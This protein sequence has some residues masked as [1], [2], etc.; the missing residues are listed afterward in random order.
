MT[1]KSSKLML[2]IN[3]MEVLGTK[4]IV[5]EIGCHNW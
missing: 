1:S 2:L 5:H 4:M 3:G